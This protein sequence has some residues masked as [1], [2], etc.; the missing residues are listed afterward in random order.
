MQLEILPLDSTLQ[1][2]L[3]FRRG[4]WIRAPGQQVRMLYMHFPIRNS[5]LPR[6]RAKVSH[7]ILTATTHRAITLKER[8]TA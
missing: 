5:H 3:F 8:L 6:Q 7:T 1:A 4:V 2:E